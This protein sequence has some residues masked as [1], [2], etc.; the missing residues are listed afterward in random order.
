[1]PELG[2]LPETGAQIKNQEPEFNLKFNIGAGAVVIWEVAQAAGP[3]IDG[4][5]FAK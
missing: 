2:I 1:M 5:D 3:F 4:Y